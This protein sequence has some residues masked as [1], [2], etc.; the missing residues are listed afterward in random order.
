MAET[1]YTFAGVAKILDIP[2]TKLRY[3]AQIGF[4]GPSV[5]ETTRLLFSFQD[6]VLLRTAK[7]L[8]DARIPARKV[9]RALGRLRSQLPSGR[10]L[11]GGTLDNF[12]FNFL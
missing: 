4:V 8:E 1:T 6:L 3:W 11:T 10:P 9:R 2:E 7:G 12:T 5:R